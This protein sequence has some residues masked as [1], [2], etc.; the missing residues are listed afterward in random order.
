VT[1]LDEKL[2]RRRD[3]LAFYRHKTVVF[4]EVMKSDSDLD[5]GAPVAHSARF[6]IFHVHSLSCYEPLNPSSFVPKVIPAFLRPCFVL[7]ARRVSQSVFL[8]VDCQG[9]TRLANSCAV[10]QPDRNVPGR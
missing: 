8:I 6:L 4:S 3:R 2:Q 9:R 1:E 7:L 10:D 5:R